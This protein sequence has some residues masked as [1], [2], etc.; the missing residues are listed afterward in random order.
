MFY[1]LTDRHYYQNGQQRQSEIFKS[2]STGHQ[3]NRHHP[4][5]LF[6]WGLFSCCRVDS[7]GAIVISKRDKSLETKPF[8]EHHYTICNNIII[9]RQIVQFF[10]SYFPYFFLFSS[11]F[12]HFTDSYF[13][14]F[15]GNISA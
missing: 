3:I 12:F 15:W 14:T 5:F 11:Y 2:W 1:F 13:P 7:S 8:L 4:K 6:Y 9:M 10:P